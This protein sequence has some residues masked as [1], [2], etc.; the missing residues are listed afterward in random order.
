MNPRQMLL[1]FGHGF[2]TRG[3]TT[4][5]RT[6]ALWATLL[7]F[8]H[9]FITRGGL[10]VRPS[11]RRETKRLQFGHGFITRGGRPG[12]RRSHRR[13]ALQF[14]HGFITRGGR[15]VRACRARCGL[16]SIRP[17][18][19]HPWRARSRPTRRRDPARFNSATGSSPV[20]GD[21]G[22]APRVR[23]ARASIRPRVHHPWRSKWSKS[24]EA[25]AAVLQ[26]G[27]GFI[28][29]GGSQASRIRYAAAVLQFGHG[30]ITRGGGRRRGREGQGQGRFNSATGSSPVEGHLDHGFGPEHVRASI[31]PRVHHPWRGVIDVQVVPALAGLQFGHGFITRGGRLWIKSPRVAGS[32]FN[33]ATGSS[34]VEASYTFAA[35]A[36]ATT[37]Q[38]GHGFITRGGASRIGF[39]SF[40]LRASIRPR[41]HHPWRHAQFVSSSPSS[42]ALQF[43]HGFITR[44]GCRGARGA[45]GPVPA[46]IRPRVHHPWRYATYLL[47]ECVT[48]GFNSATGSSPVEVVGTGGDAVAAML[49]FGHGFITRGGHARGAA[50]VKWSE[51]QFGHGFITRGGCCPCRVRPRLTRCFNSAT[52]SSPVEGTWAT[53]DLD[54]LRAVL[55]FGHGFITRGGHD[56]RKSFATTDSISYRERWD[57]RANKRPATRRERRRKL[58]SHRKLRAASGGKA[59][60]R[61]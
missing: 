29:R 4:L 5:C 19:H 45:R 33:S 32:S 26:F 60:F 9:G 6:A 54:G 20:E 21:R 57:V 3:G 34:P 50:F 56:I 11:P 47:A 13:P 28:T 40:R 7:Q 17:R 38:F 41:V 18:V 1:Q 46:S 27:H 55:Q 49:Q 36:S 25:R 48:Y 8:G 31:R 15:A 58:L 14:G 30:F 61:S 23:E 35:A 44:G 16:A 53:A 42:S 24:S 43:G 2:I 10:S 12:G 51:L 39:T 52:G 37:L 22:V 59:H